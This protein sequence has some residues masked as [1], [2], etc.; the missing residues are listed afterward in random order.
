[1]GGITKLS[2]YLKHIDFVEIQS[3]D[4]PCRQGHFRASNNDCKQ[5][6]SNHG[7][8]NSD[9]KNCLICPE[10]LILESSSMIC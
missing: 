4:I 5:C 3:E 8:I 7:F 9:S 1:M 10:G 6:E 2:K